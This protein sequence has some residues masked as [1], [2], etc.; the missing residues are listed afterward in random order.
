MNLGLDSEGN[1]IC[2]NREDSKTEESAEESEFLIPSKTIHINEEQETCPLCRYMK[3]GSCRDQFIGWDK[4]MSSLKE[5]DQIS[6]CS[7][8]T[9]ELFQCMTKDEYYDIMTVNSHNILPALEVSAK[10]S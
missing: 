8:P 6:K 5:K 3:K 7:K 1:C 9:F 10:S 4:C 2:E